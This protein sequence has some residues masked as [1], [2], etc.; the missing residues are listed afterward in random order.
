MVA[1]IRGLTTI[2]RMQ[3]HQLQASYQADQDRILL[4]LNTHSGEEMRV[5]LTRRMLKGMLVHVQRL[6]DQIQ[7]LRPDAAMADANEDEHE[8]T[9]VLDQDFETPFE[10]HAE[11]ALPL[12][13]LPLLTTALHVAPDADNSLKVRF[14][15]VPDGN[16]EPTRSM[17]VILGPDL[18]VGFVQILDAVL[19]VTD[20]GMTLHSPLPAAPIQ[21]SGGKLL[22]DFSNATRPKYLN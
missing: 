9:T 2:G 19:R 5:W 11:A 1:M 22:D 3:I 20:W 10:D 6:A 15:E 14:D 4:R 13:E 8:T 17:E 18:L 16:S 7:A 12:G 21:E